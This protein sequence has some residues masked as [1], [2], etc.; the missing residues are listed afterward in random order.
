MQDEPSDTVKEFQEALSKKA[1]A[2]KNDYKH[3]E[4]MCVH[5]QKLSNSDNPFRPKLTLL[6]FP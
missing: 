4:N 2:D 6:L 1:F 3:Y 5:P